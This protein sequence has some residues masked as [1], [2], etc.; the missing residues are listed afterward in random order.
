LEDRD[1]LVRAAEIL[2]QLVRDYPDIVEY[3]VD[4]AETYAM[5]DGGPGAE[6]YALWDGGPDAVALVPRAVDLL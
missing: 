6:P 4:L 3:R 5:W 2:E 1:H